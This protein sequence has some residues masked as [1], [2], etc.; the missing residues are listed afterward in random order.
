[1]KEVSCKVFDVLIR[2]LRKKRIAPNVLIEGT[3]LDAATLRNKNERVDWGVYLAVMRNS[4]RYFDDEEYVRMGGSFL[5]SPLIRPFAVIGRLLFTSHDHYRW[6]SSGR[7]GAGGQL[8]TCIEP[9][10]ED[11]SP[12]RIAIELKLPE[13]YE[14]CWDFFLITKGTLIALP[15]LLGLR[16]AVVDM[17]PI[18]RGARYEIQVPAGGGLLVKLKR[19]L[20]WTTSARVAARELKDANEALTQRYEQL[21]EARNRLDRQATQLKTAHSISRLIH[22]D[23]DLLRSLDLIVDALVKVGGFRGARVRVALDLEGRRIEQAASGGERSS[24]PPIALQLSGRHREMGEV[25][26]W[27]EAR[28]DVEK[29]ALMDYVLPIISM[30]IDNALTFTAVTDYRA[31]LERKVEE[32]TEQLREAQRAR[33]RIFANVNHEIRTPLSLITLAVSD[34][35][36]HARESI[37]PRV[38][39]SLD[40]I[41]LSARNLLQ[42]VDGLLLLAA[43]AE[44]KLSLRFAAM[45]LS[46]IV[47]RLSEAWRPAIEG[48]GLQLELDLP[49]SC[50]AEVDEAAF[51]RVIANLLSNAVKFTPAPGR[52]KVELRAHEGEVHFAVSDTGV[53]IDEAFKSRMFGR[54]E[55][56]RPAVRA[57]ARGSG[58][59]LSIVKELVDRHGGRLS[60]EANPGGG[61]VFRVVLP[62]AQQRGR[63]EQESSMSAPDTSPESFGIYTLDKRESKIAEPPRDA[64]ATILVAE[65]DPQLRRE[66][67]ELLRDNHR[68]LAACDG[69][70]AMDLAQRFF[71]DL[72]I[73]DIAM[74]RMD[75]FELTRRF[76]ELPGNRLAPV[77]LLTAFGG[78]GDRLSGFDAGALDYVLKPFEPEELLARIRSQ[79]A[80]RDLALRLHDSEK[81]ASLGVLSAGLAHEIRN[82]ANAVV[83]AILPLKQSLPGELVAPE[84]AS[85]Q[86]LGLIEE[87]A[88]QIARLSRQLLGSTRHGVIAHQEE[89]F[90]KILGRALL[91]V[92]PVT[93]Q[94]TI[95]KSLQYAGPVVCAAPLIGQV[96]V[97]LIENAAQ[98]AGPG[99]WV[100]VA[101]SIEADRLIVDVSDSG[102][103]VPPEL[104]DR[105]FEPFFTTKPPGAG[106]GLGLTTSRQIVEQHSGT[107]KVVHGAERSLFRL[108]L[109]LKPRRSESGPSRHAANLRE[110]A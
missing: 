20:S 105:I 87:G 65:D 76:R 40:S 92:A 88:E 107:L 44:N 73:S 33:D 5:R 79:L 43:G 97:N 83:N 52:I 67:V 55:Q 9:S 106:T 14:A 81:L 70:E 4:R 84:T 77:V 59:G 57:G 91:T 85:G 56:G 28:E 64:E 41:E 90:A 30:A 110:G 34:I 13:G 19:A 72:L 29:R 49:P 17:V 50:S 101:S 46:N 8:F 68:V 102:P 31:N 58:I 75:G 27:L 60:V 24:V 109:P 98:A 26:L 82:P 3:T 86:L 32:R 100:N 11:L 1:V 108:E 48:S 95:T 2:E 37:A 25:E 62:C 10:C 47:R 6:L 94:V 66:I 7:A 22:S 54:F 18:P 89:P 16:D 51:D 74:P 96:L 35:K 42:L 45:D 93:R 39:Q 12:D 69:V 15:N 61:S 53:G 104:K 21:E 23:L 78:I 99:G 36:R 63:P 80:Q 38:R 103:G 71:P